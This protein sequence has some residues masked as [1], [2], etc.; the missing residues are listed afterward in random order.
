[1]EAV[2]TVFEQFARG[3][4]SAWSEVGPD[5]EFI[6]SPDMPDPGTYTGEAADRYRQAWLDSFEELQ[7]EALELVDAGERIVVAEVVQRGRPR[8]TEIAVEGRWWQV[9]TFRGDDVVRIENFT[10]RAEALA[11]AR[12]SS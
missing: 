1:M 3:D 2:R 12:L 4:F 5:F 8:G 6:T 11:A 10:G 9:I 7:M